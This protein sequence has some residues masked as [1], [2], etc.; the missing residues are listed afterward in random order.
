[1]S[2]ISNGTNRNIRTTLFNRYL[3]QIQSKS[4]YVI[5]QIRAVSVIRVVAQVGEATI[6]Y[7]TDHPH[8]F[9]LTS[10]MACSLS[11]DQSVVPQCS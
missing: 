11:A 10:P 1:M 5:T 8:K 3:V 6:Q 9:V 7:V 4:K 2:T